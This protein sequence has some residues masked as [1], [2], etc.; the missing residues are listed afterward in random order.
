MLSPLLIKTA[1]SNYGP[2]PVLTVGVDSRERNTDG[3][4]FPIVLEVDGPGMFAGF[5]R[6]T[7]SEARMI[8]DALN[9]AAREAA[10]LNG[11]GS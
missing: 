7:C 6:L 5:A 10:V 4:W 8:A 2:K 9:G 1:V 3:P 11:G